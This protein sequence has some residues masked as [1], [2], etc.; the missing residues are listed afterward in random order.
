VGGSYVG[1]EFAQMYRRFG[2]RVT[3]IEM[4]PRLVGRED[5]DVAA[6]IQAI[7]E[8]EGIAFRLNAQCVAVRRLG[9]GVAVH[10]SCADEPHEATGSHVLLAVGRVPN[11]G[12]L[13]LERAGV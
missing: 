12:D 10:L 1:L 2:S 6:A 4:G 13:G 11:T 3:V 5:E 8:A 7:L 9:D